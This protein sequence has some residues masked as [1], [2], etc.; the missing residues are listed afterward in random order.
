MLTRCK[1]YSI[2]LI[3]GFIAC[4][5][6]EMREKKIAVQEAQLFTESFGDMEN[7]AILLM[8]GAT[9][10]MLFWDE[11]FCQRLSDQ[12]YFVIRYDNRDVGESTWYPPGPPPYDLEDLVD[13]AVA[14]L[15]GYD[16]EKA[17]F[18]G[19]SLGA[20]LAQISAVKYPQRVESIGLIGT[21]P[22]GPSDPGIP[23][24]DTRILDFQA[25]AG[26]VDWS[27]EDSVVTYMLEGAELISG[28]K[29]FD[30]KRG[31]K[32]IREEFRR[33]GNY[34]SMYNHALLQGGEEFY[35][36]LEE[37]NQ[38][39]LIMH[40]TDDRIWHFRHAEVLHREMKHSTLVPLVDT[41]HELHHE[42]W[43][44]MIREISQHI[45]SGE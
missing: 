40:G 4:N 9:V 27:D 12:G 23:E 39:V 18:I 22:F 17:H 15:D 2:L 1:K 20:L 37:I 25:N 26:A 33:A 21:G 36:R 34:R 19:M 13:D 29:G 38:P 24:M 32:L 28:S 3:L 14:I 41:G 10:S 6:K 16:L 43:D 42:D 11:E 45:R 44:I 31:E 30:D 7:P 8:G 5:N 35:G